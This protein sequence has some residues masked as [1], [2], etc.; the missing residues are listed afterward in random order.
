MV[1]MAFID[2]LDDSVI[3][4]SEQVD[5]FSGCYDLLKPVAYC[6]PWG[7]EIHTYIAGEEN[8]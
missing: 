8:R 7:F 4:I 5:K 1:A 2:N 3:L 6:K